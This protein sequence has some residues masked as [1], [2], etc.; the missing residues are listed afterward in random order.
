M[1]FNRNPSYGTGFARSRYES[2]YPEM[3]NRL[4]LAVAP[5]LGAT[6]DNI[7]DWSGHR[8]DGALTNTVWGAGALDFNGTSSII[9]CGNDSILE[10]V[11]EQA[12]SICAWAKV[13]TQDTDRQFFVTKDNDTLDGRFQ[14]RMDATDD[15][16]ANIPTFFL[17]TSGPTF[18]TIEGATALVTG[19]WH[20]ICATWD[21]STLR[22]Y[23]DGI[24]DATPL[25]T[26]GTWASDGGVDLIIGASDTPSNY[27]DGKIEQV[28][29]YN[30]CLTPNE[31]AWLYTNPKGLFI[32]NPHRVGFV[33][34]AP[35]A[36]FTP[37]VIFI[38]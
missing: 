10:P 34:A 16:P 8:N 36:T 25:A 2:A 18:N 11:A 26:T 20:F 37:Q 24:S 35:A 13:D 6:G 5:L 12:Y 29:V 27:F 23:L 14:L 17:L 32:R 31:V 22:L 30:R 33:A 3:W 15:S 38:M 28:L 4:V 1:L 9:N 19:R 7:I 21:G